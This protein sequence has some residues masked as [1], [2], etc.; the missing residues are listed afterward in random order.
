MSLS[1]EGSTSSC[2]TSYAVFVFPSLPLQFLRVYPL[3]GIYILR[4]QKDEFRQFLF[5]KNLHYS[6]KIPVYSGVVIF[7]L[8]EYN[9]NDII[10][11]FLRAVGKTNGKSSYLAMVIANVTS[12]CLN[13]IYV[14]CYLLSKVA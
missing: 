11:L 5:S 10:Y 3:S 4:S 2:P 6:L 1:Y 14:E 12:S 7:K 13:V 8:P 9:L